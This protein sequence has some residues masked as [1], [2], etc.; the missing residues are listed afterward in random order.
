MLITEVKK[1]N[2]QIHSK[3]TFTRFVKLWSF[4]QNYV[5]HQDVFNFSKPL[6]KREKK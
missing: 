1:K 3:P 5:T 2:L 6:L 4:D